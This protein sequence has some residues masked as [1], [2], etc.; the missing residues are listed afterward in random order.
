MRWHG[1]PGRHGQHSI[2]GFFSWPAGYWSRSITTSGKNGPRKFLPLVWALI[3]LFSTWQH[4]RYEYYLAVVIALLSA[5][6]IHFVFEKGWEDLR[7]L[8]SGIMSHAAPGGSDEAKKTELRHGAGA[9]NSERRKVR[10]F[11]KIGLPC[12]W[13]CGDRVRTRHSLYVLHQ[14]PII[15]RWRPA[16]ST[17]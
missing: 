6:C 3:I 12:P 17:Q 1:L 14:F 11:P 8:A 13:G 9:K 16:E 7:T 4:V 2:T 5:V 15:T 10:Q